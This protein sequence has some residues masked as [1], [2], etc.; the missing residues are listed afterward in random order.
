M[1]IE[2]DGQ[3]FLRVEP[4]SEGASWQVDYRPMRVRTKPED[5]P[6]IFVQ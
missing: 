6:D 5:E 3:Y 1:T 2:C 4:S